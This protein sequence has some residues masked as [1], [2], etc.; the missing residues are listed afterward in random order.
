M[1]ETAEAE[2][3]RARAA[4]R[5]AERGVEAA[6]ARAAQA[7]AELAAVNQYLRSA[8]SAP[9]GSATL[10]QSLEVEPGYELAL[11]A[12]LGPRLAAALVDDLPAGERLLDRHGEKGGT[13]LLRAGADR[14]ARG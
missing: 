8:S 7:G 11:A 3:E 5:E 4:R 2:V 13:A 10:A 9:D 12:A 1:L 6:R 14:V